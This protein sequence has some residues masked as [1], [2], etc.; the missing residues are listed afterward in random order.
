LK[1]ARIRPICRRCVQ[2]MID[3]ES[4][5]RSSAKP[6]SGHRSLVVP[7]TL[8]P[9]A[10]Q[11]RSASCG[12][13]GSDD[14]EVM[15]GLWNGE[16]GLSRESGPLA[17]SASGPF[18]LLGEGWDVGELQ[19]ASPVGPTLLSGAGMNVWQECRARE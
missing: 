8:Y 14:G 11:K 17:S 12:V 16:G 13:I 15:M 3:C 5:D 6:H 9:H 19:T 4:F 7:R 2:G 10:G 18:P 1:Y